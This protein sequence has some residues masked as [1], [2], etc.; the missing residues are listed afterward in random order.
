MDEPRWKQILAGV[1]EAE[2]NLAKEILRD[3][4]KREGQDVSEE[5]LDSMAER[6][7]EQARTVFKKKGRQT[8]R[9]LKAGLKA[10]WDEVK[11]EA[12]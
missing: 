4:L 9:G 6:A 1:S 10:F 2:R 7:V 3:R 5:M 8:L 12:E 11:R